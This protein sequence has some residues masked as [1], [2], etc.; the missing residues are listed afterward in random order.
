L[1]AE[2]EDQTARLKDRQVKLMNVQTNR[3]YQSL[4]REIEEAKKTNNSRE[5]EVVRLMEQAEADQ[6][7]IVDGLALCEEEED[8]LGTI[9]KQIAAKAKEMA[10]NKAKIEKERDDKAKKI[11]VA[12]LKKYEL[13]RAKRNGVAVVGVAN[14]VC[15]GCYMNIP[16]QLYN[17]LLRD[18][19]LL[20]CP[21]C[22]R[23]LYNKES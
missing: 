14:G 6:K 1:E 8:Q 5:E 15:Q 13:L 21:T 19:D 7:T 11:S 12:H 23:M 16:P 10:A 18:Q 17:D 20:S 22:N 4:L 2:T 3:E 9:S